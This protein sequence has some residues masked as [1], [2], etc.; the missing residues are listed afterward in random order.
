[1]VH[2]HL[3]AAKTLSLSAIRAIPWVLCWTQ[4]RVLFPTWWGIGSA[5]Q[6]FKTD[7]NLLNSLKN[8]FRHNSQFASYVKL[9]G[10]SLRKVDLN[11]WELYLEQSK[12]EPKQ[13]D[14][15]K[16]SFRHE[17][18]LASDFV[19]SVSGQTH[20]LWFRPWLDESI[21]LRSSMIH[22]L[23][24]IQILAMQEKRHVSAA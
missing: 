20:L 3:R 14:N 4:T 16:R 17:Y 2:A 21:A 10:F 5:W 1:M 24:M 11:I 12:L 18:E 15:I 13:I 8:G 9:I 22:P 6:E 7:P 23:N 19:K